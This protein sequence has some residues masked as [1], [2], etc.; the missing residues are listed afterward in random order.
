MAEEKQDDIPV[1]DAVEEVED[2]SVPDAGEEVQAFKEGPV[3]EEFEKGQ[4]V[5]GKASKR[6]QFDGMKAKS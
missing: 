3:A 5:E 1:Q 2:N 4:W 6:G